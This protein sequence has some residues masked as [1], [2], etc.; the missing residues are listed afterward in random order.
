MAKQSQSVK[1]LPGLFE[2]SKNSVRFRPLPLEGHP[3][4]DFPKR[5]EI[6]GDS[7]GERLEFET[8]NSYLST[9]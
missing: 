3:F 2:D 7:V 5:F 4:L 6:Y 8:L 1:S 9:E